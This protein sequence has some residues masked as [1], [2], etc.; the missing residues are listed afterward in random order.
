VI[1][2][3]SESGVGIRPFD[4]YLNDVKWRI[5]AVRPRAD[6]AELMR[7]PMLPHRAASDA[8]SA[9]RAHHIPYDFTMDPREH[10]AQFCSEVAFAAYEPLGI[11]LWP[12]L[13][14]IS[15]P[16]AASWLAAFGVRNLEFQEPSDLEYDPKLVVVA[17]WR[18]PKALFL[19]HVDNAIVD[20]RLE[21]AERG[22]RLAYDWPMLPIA[23][24]IKAWSVLLNLFG[25]V[26][27]APEGMSATAALRNV[28]FAREHAAIRERLLALAEEFE[29]GRG[30]LAPYSELV[31]MARAALD[32]IR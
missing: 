6:L 27:P 18:D 13:S 17:E 22:A 31:R 12:G 15:S 16:G 7:D 8:L 11:E 3:H 23:R 28:R 21:E 9:A 24:G 25:G 4:E 2:A 30:Y 20:A 5:L 26:G 19:D 29:R 14:T 10:S 1:E 32:E